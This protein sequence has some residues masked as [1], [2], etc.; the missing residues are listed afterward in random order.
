[1]VRGNVT[2]ELSGSRR[3]VQ[4]LYWCRWPDNGVMRSPKR[5]LVR[6]DH[7]S[8]PRLLLG[9]GG[10]ALFAMIGA[11]GGAESYLRWPAIS[12]FVLSFLSVPLA[13]VPVL[14]ATTGSMSHRA[15]ISAGFWVTVVVVFAVVGLTLR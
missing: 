8:G 4:D 14:R 10:M 12:G 5:G 7:Q 15:M 9:F 11:S 3:N 13:V 2:Y 1:M 6:W